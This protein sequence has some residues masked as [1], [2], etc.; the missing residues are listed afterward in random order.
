MAIPWLA[1]QGTCAFEAQNV[2]KL[3]TFDQVEKNKAAGQAATELSAR[4][5]DLIKE[6]MGKFTISLHSI[7]LR[8]IFSPPAP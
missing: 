2:V 4:L 3:L 5:A 6:Y 1:S 7:Q 8:R